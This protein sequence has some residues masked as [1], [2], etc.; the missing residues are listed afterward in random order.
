MKKTVV[1]ACLA[2]LLPFLCGAGLPPLFDNGATEWKIEVATNAAPA[3][4]FAVEE[5]TN[6]LMCVSGVAFDVVAPGEGG[7]HAVRFVAGDAENFADEVVEYRVDGGHLILQGNLPRATLHA[8]YAFLQRELG[9]RW[10]WPGETGAFFPKLEKWAVPASLAF[11]HTPS[12]KYRGF[13]HC[14]DWR[15]RAAFNL[16]QTRNFATIHRHGVAKGEEKYGQYSMISMHNANLN[17]EKELFAEH[18]ECFCELAGHRSMINICFSSELGAE[19]V[20]ARLAAQIEGFRRRGAPLDIVSIFPND[21][22]DYCQCAKC[23]ALGVSTAW[24][25]YY[26]KVVK[27]L[28]AK[29]PDL[30]FAT[31]AYQGYL[32]V[33]DC[34]IENTEFIEYASHPRCHI[35]KWG[36]E[37]CAANVGEL[38]RLKAWCARGDV[39]VGHYAYE[40]DAISKHPVFMPFFSMIGDA[41]ETVVQN[42][43][44]TSIPE[45]SL[46]PKGGPDVTAH[47]VQ[48]RLT[49]LF[50][51]RKM[52]DVRLTLDDFLADTCRTAFGP[53]A[54]PMAEYFRAMDAVWGA[55][56]G[57]I[58]LFAD[59]MNVSANLLADD[60]VRARAAALLAEAE[61]LAQG[62][63]TALRNVL[64]EKIL[65]GQMASYRE[66]R[67]GNAVAVNLPRL[68]TG[69]A[70][71]DALA[72]WHALV[73]VKD[74]TPGGIGA[75]LAWFVSPD[76]KNNAKT[77][78]DKLVAEWRGTD[79]AT[80]SIAGAGGERYAFWVGKEGKGQR[81]IS[82]VGVEETTWAPDWTVSTL[83]DR[84]VFEIPFT[85]FVNRPVADEAWEVRLSAPGGWA[86]PQRE[87]VMAKMS[88]LAAGAVDRPIVYYAGDPRCHRGI[89]G[90]RTQGEADGWK[91][92][93]CTNDAEV[94]AVAG[95][96]ETFMFQVP[97]GD[98][99][100][101]NTAEVIRA[102]VRAGG[103]LLVRSWWSPP[104][105]RIL[106][107]KSLDVRCEAPK[108]YPLGERHAKWVM[109]GDWCKAP[110]NMEGAVRH[111]FAPCYMQVPY[112]PEG[113]VQYAKMPAQADESRLIPFVSALKYGD[114]AVIVV[115]ETLGVSHFRLIDNIRRDLGLR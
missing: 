43:L 83:A 2:A 96:A 12:V 80:L 18:P 55:Q 15:D 5:F 64:R 33:P 14:G 61:K 85:A 66:L 82:D 3:V 62:D 35:H 37:T 113:W 44:A 39:A 111:G 36:D 105:A 17:G 103:T 79:A 32:D 27:I 34:K 29:Y 75:R 115:G 21:N 112:A 13:H 74:G 1:S 16:W 73:G 9:V 58:G 88:F 101:S 106:G 87:D 77:V 54:K 63:E 100:A 51:A 108:D 52:W 24:F 25:A 99:V 93:A 114:G 45:V 89:P 102:K 46:S 40:Y 90:V 59:G 86:F 42:H 76:P 49:Q 4:A 98:C 71:G 97:R 30:R 19:K 84:L 22:Q 81:K 53:A 10:L 95:K 8:A 28:K 67:L 48:N 23:K 26:N 110:W 6:A 60:K 65:Y 56:P 94:A 109:E 107:D 31:L 11:R 41:V 47:A 68:K 7:G 91:V 70:F 50:Y 72:P 78:A 20:A 92:F 104:L 57:R 69:E 38:K